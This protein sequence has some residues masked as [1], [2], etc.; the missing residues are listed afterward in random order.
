MMKTFAPMAALTVCLAAASASA[1]AVDETT[2]GFG[3]FKACYTTDPDGK[4]GA[5]V[6]TLDEVVISEPEQKAVGTGTVTWPSVGPSFQPIKSPISGP[7]YWM[8]T[9]KSCAFRLDFASAPGARG[10]KGSLVAPNWGHPGTFS[11]EL[12]GGSEQVNQKAKPCD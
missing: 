7:W 5:P 8:C 6:L 12:D 11:Y 2:K 10:L 1:L 9:N 4:V 3:A